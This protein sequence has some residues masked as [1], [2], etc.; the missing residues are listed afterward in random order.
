MTGTRVLSALVVHPEAAVRRTLVEALRL[1]LP[2]ASLHA[3]EAGTPTQALQTASWLE[4]RLVLL[5]LATDRK[6][7]LDVARTLRQPGRVLLGLYNPMLA[8]DR[9]PG[10]R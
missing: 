10:K 5:D 2:N 3:A 6:L 4:P 7:A 1:A 8:S 9:L